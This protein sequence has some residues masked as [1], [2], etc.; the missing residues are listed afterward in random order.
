MRQITQ[1]EQFFSDVRV[2]EARKK[3]SEALSDHQKKIVGIRGPHSKLKIPYEQY[4]QSFSEIRGAK[5]FFPYLGS[6]FGQG[7]FVELADGS[8]KYDFISGIGTHYFGHN[9]QDLML[10]TLDAAL[11]D[12]VLQGNLQQN[13]ESLDVSKSLLSL[14]NKNGASFAHCFLSTSGAMANENALKLIFQKKQPA[15]RILAFERCFAGRTIVLSRIT[16][17]PSFR[18]GLP[19]ALP[20]DYVPFFDFKNPKTSIEKSCSA[21]KKHLSLYPKQHAL[22]MFELIQGEGGYFEGNRDFFLALIRILKKHQIAVF[23]DEIQTF[24][25]TSEPFAFQYYALDK[26]VDV[27]TVGKLTQVAATLFKKEWNPAPGLLS[28][29]FTGNTA[30]LLAA[31]TI[32]SKLSKENYF[33]S[34][35]KIMCLHRHFVSRLKKL[36]ERYPDLIEGPFGVGAMIAFT[37]F[38]G[39]PAKVNR[40]VQNLFHK[41]VIAFIAGENPVRV[42]FLPPVG[43]ATLKDVDEVMKIVEATLNETMVSLPHQ[44]ALK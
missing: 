9:A 38:K 3:L 21:L 32:L 10:S 26:Y 37:P 33:G 23:F 24:G 8:V 39:D 18:Q 2:S 11:R 44:N 27:C 25:R 30:S 22:M 6:G 36:S 29:T 14:A 34:Q 5:L 16:D 35:G 43:V 15:S 40:F 1:A 17:K 4:L 42:R 12:T 28:Q 41:G 13:L 19:P 31:K 7:V 20:V